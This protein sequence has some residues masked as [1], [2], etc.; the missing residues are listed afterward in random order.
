MKKWCIF[1]VIL[2]CG[3]FDTVYGIGY[4][5]YGRLEVHPSFGTTGLYTSNLNQTAENE[6]AGFLTENKLGL[7][8]F[9]PG[10]VHLL[11]I[12]YGLNLYT[13]PKVENIDKTFYPKN[14]ADL[15][16]E[17]N[18]PGGIYTKLNEFFL[19]TISPASGEEAGVVERTQNTAG[20]NLGYKSG[21]RYN[22]GLGY[23]NI[24]HD[25]KLDVYNDLDRMEQAVGPVVYL[26]VFNKTSLLIDYKYGIINYRTERNGV[27]IDSNEHNIMAGVTGKIT[28]K[29]TYEVKGGMASRKYKEPSLEGFSTP[30]AGISLIAH[31]SALW[32]I[33]LKFMRRAY[34]SNWVQN[35]YFY[36]NKTDLGVNWYPTSKITAKIGAGY[37]LNQYNNEALNE[38][39]GEMTKRADG[40]LSFGLNLFYD[41]QRWLKMGAGYSL[42]SR[43]SNFNIWDYSENRISFGLFLIL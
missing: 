35:Y 38:D 31:P 14:S 39:T 19:E 10:D 27:S 22:I 9:W 43:N 13:F 33:D 24:I 7:G 11:S 16:L 21:D 32:S 5:H 25:Y 37:E 40:V 42:R 41:V 28:S 1:F 20:L 23:T 34:E 30:I 2:F 29:L 18:F 12:D 15:L 26:K 17:L 4:I 8:I 3:I 36:Q 6:Q